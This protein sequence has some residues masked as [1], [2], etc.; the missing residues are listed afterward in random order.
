MAHVHDIIRCP[1]CSVSLRL[2]ELPIVAT[3][4]HDGATA[5]H[6]ARG[7]ES[8]SAAGPAPATDDG[9]PGAAR[10]GFDDGLDLGGPRPA[11][12]ASSVR[13][14][15]AESPD[16]PA[17]R[18]TRPASGAPVRRWIA[19]WPVVAPPPLAEARARQKAA[20]LAQTPPKG[21]VQRWLDTMG[22]PVEEVVEALGPLP[23]LTAVASPA[24]RPARLCTSC[25]FPLPSAID[26]RDYFTIAVVGVNYAS[27]TNFI[28]SALST[29]FRRRGLQPLGCREFV[30]DGPTGARFVDDYFRPMFLNRHSL[31]HTFADPN[32]YSQ[33]PVLRHQAARFRP[34]VMQATFPRADRA[35]LLLFHDIAGEDFSDHARRPIVAPFLREADAIIYVVDPRWLFDLMPRLADGSEYPT[36]D[37]EVVFGSML[38]DLADSSVPI[39]VA[40][41]K[42]D[43]LRPHVPDHLRIF[44]PPPKT[45]DEWLDDLEVVDRE[46][47]EIV[48]GFGGDAFIERA[49]QL[50]NVRFCAMAPIGSST[51]DGG[52]I[53]T[54]AP[55]RVLDPLASVLSRIPALRV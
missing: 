34:L 8:R 37:Q 48:G 52:P 23:S 51:T 33:D 40:L 1:F 49:E 36:G 17:G 55:V 46:V 27:K 19:G 29:A 31:P 30:P 4:F 5:G 39:C 13:G 42:S 21:R 10:S 26:D 53:E 11:P 28:G 43:L 3:N 15:D 47:R 25:E 35:S 24:D 16:P 6:E 45:R 18:T 20:A 22:G 14:G 12:V 32:A 9:R 50:P 2:G 44:A 54:L 38:D 7:A 41:S